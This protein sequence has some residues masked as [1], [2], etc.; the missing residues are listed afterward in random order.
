MRKGAARAPFLFVR[1]A[2]RA[3]QAART[4]ST[5]LWTWVRS[6]TAWRDRSVAEDSTC[7]AAEAEAWAA[8]STELMLLVTSF[9][10]VAACWMLR[11]TSEVVAFCSSMA[12]AMAVAPARN[13]L[14]VRLKLEIDDTT[15]PVES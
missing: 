3:D 7:W 12:A 14:M 5:K 2:M 4:V 13:S 6:D 10:P 8:R 15:S 11:A 1:R 9:V